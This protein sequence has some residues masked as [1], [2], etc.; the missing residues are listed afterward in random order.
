MQ[1][2]LYKT[3]LLR[4]RED[5]SSVLLQAFCQTVPLSSDS[6]PVNANRGCQCPVSGLPWPCLFTG[7]T[8]WGLHCLWDLLWVF[9]GKQL[10]EKPV[11][12]GSQSW[13]GVRC[14]NGAELQGSR[15]VTVSRAAQR[16]S[17]GMA[18]LTFLG[19]SHPHPGCPLLFLCLC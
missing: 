8:L 11:S 4:N 15:A 10:P 19:C 16:G 5:P 2:Q 3:T 13:P 1:K 17:K 12:R 18:H 14:E 6:E 7:A 9:V